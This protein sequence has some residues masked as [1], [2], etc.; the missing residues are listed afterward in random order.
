MD[1]PA[2]GVNAEAEMGTL[3]IDAQLCAQ[4]QPVCSSGGE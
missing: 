1:A 3:E 2:V 4:A